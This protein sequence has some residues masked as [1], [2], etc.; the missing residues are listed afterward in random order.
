MSSTEISIEE[1]IYVKP[2][3]RLKT[4]TKFNNKMK[5]FLLKEYNK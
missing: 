5:N 1:N 4:K 3:Y 2:I